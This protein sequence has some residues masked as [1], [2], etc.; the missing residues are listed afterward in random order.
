MVTRI[1]LLMTILIASA[2]MTFAQDNDPWVGTWT[3]EGYTD[4][5]CKRTYDPSNMDYDGSV[6]AVYKTTK[7]LV[8]RITQNGGNYLI[9]TKVVNQN[10]PNDVSYGWECHVTK[11]SGNTIFYETQL[12]KDPQENNGRITEYLNLTYY[13]KLTITNGTL[14]FDLYN[15]KCITYD[16]GM[17]FVKEENDNS[18]IN[19]TP[20]SHLTLFNDDW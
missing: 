4:V 8:I 17:R 11:V 20:G 16:S 15:F 5:D 6:K 14:K 18:W 19:K 3:S 10:D 12:N 9:R 1:T 7:K 2:S 13:Y